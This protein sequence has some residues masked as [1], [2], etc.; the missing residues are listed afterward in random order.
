MV[1]EPFVDPPRPPTKEQQRMLVELG[2]QIDKQGVQRYT[3]ETQPYAGPVVYA[4]GGLLVWKVVDDL[5]AVD[6][7]WDGAHDLFQP[8][9]YERYLWPEPV[10]R[11]HGGMIGYRE[12][13]NWE[14]WAQ[15]ENLVLRQAQALQEAAMDADVDRVRVSGIR[16]Q[17]GVQWFVWD[18]WNDVGQHR[19]LKYM[20]GLQAA[21]RPGGDF[22]T[23]TEQLKEIGVRHV[24][25]LFY[26]EM[27][28]ATS[29]WIYMNFNHGETEIVTMVQLLDFLATLDD[30]EGLAKR[31][32]MSPY[33]TDDL[34][35]GAMLY[36]PERW[37]KPVIPG[38][39][40]GLRYHPDLPGGRDDPVVNI[41]GE[42]WQYGWIMNPDNKKDLIPREY[43]LPHAARRL[44]Q[45]GFEVKLLEPSRY[46]LFPSR[47]G[48]PVHHSSRVLWGW[49]PF[50]DI[51]AMNYPT[52]T[53]VPSLWTDRVFV[54]GETN[55]I[56]AEA[57]NGD[58]PREW[59]SSGFFRPTDGEAR[60]YMPLTEY[61]VNSGLMGNNNG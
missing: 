39:F 60:R 22:F 54:V 34:V 4:E 61:L 55:S 31:R 51:N 25:S 37:H 19:I 50:E 42:E 32:P 44:W 48:L 8:L 6:I 24:D 41:A 45:G 16:G 38:Q 14:M 7:D 46:Q 5:Y 57:G 3:S 20:A 52:E 30:A 12:P 49:A 23:I 56:R 47:T 11:L 26:E 53:I 2:R 18:P 1:N 9:F 59:W 13:E 27:S 40:R 35:V 21:N 29:N 58:H 43:I 33:K 36:G 10:A 17:G 15:A 28:P